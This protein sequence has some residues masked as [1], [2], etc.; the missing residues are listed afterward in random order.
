MQKELNKKYIAVF[1]AE[2]TAKTNECKGIQEMIQCALLIFSLDKNENGQFLSDSVEKYTVYTKTQYNKK[3]SDFII[4]LTGI[5]EQNVS[6]G[7]NLNDVMDKIIS[8]LEKYEIESVFV[9][10]PDSKILSYNLEL[11]DYPRKKA[12]Q[13]LDKIVDIS[14]TVSRS[15]N[16]KRTLSQLK[17]CKMC[18]LKSVGKNHNAPDD[19]LNLAALINANKSIILN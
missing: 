18:K 16:S 6:D 19:A 15:L 10:G 11:I 2:Y 7:E 14:K 9:W 4:S 1:D 3:L 8:Y 13:F 5:Q 12:M 17:A